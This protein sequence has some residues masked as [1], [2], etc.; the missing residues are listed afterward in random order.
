MRRLIV[1]GVIL[2]AIALLLWVF[3]PDP[4]PV[5]TARVERGN[6]TV[7]VEAEGEARVREVM[8]ISAPVTGLLQR[9]DV[10]A[11]DE[12]AA[13]L[14]VAQIGPARPPPLDS[15]A[16]AVAE[17]VA[18]A[19]AAAVELARSQLDLADA[20]RDFARTEA[21][22]ARALFSRAAISKTMLD[23]AILAE[24]SADAAVATARANVAVRE[25]E[26]ESA[27]A[28]LD[29]EATSGAACC[30]GVRSPVA[31]RILRIMTED[32]QVLQA[33]TP[34]ME[35]GDLRDMEIVV[36][37]LSRDAVEIAE[38]A[39]ATIT[40]WGGPILAARVERIA[41]SATT[42]VSAL[43]IEEQRVEVR[44]ALLQPPPPMLGHG[45]RVTARI[46]LDVA[47][48]VVRV[49]VAALFRSGA[50]WAVYSVEAGRASLH[51]VA[52][53]RRNQEFAE[54]M[55]GLEEQATIILHPS[56]SVENG[57]RILQ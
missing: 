32:E 37:V 43:G 15:R 54:V 24:R 49:P 30:I 19:A 2:A 18:A 55:T 34:I 1:G 7:S 42:R 51:V 38:G 20:T 25:K 5:E 36:H 52:I 29:S 8:V 39:E 11:G 6:L 57:V 56:D 44:L 53:G 22:R 3:L 17:A 50:D 41:P 46:T 21:D 10:H 4:V 26:L 45:F 40:G 31:G 48:D 27:Q 28:V 12:I 9:I 35:I 23:D 16:R 33:G 14:V 47:R 13:G